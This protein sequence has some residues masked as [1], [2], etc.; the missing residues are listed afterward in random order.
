MDRSG[1]IHLTIV[2]G[3]RPWTWPTARNGA[4]ANRPSIRTR[5]MTFNPG[6]TSLGSTTKTTQPRRS[7]LFCKVLFDF[8]FFYPSTFH[9]LMCC[10]RYIYIITLSRCPL[11][12]SWSVKYVR[13]DLMFNA[14]L[15]HFDPGAIMFCSVDRRRE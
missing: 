2:P 9:N 1:L 15:L 6:S 8:N 4:R 10:F 14:N 5:S 7:S 3:W 11:G 13:A 12:P